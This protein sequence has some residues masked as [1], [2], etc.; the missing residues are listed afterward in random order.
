VNKDYQ[1][2]ASGAAIVPELVM[3]DVVT[4]AEAAREG[5]L[6]LAVSRVMGQVMSSRAANARSTRQRDDVPGSGDPRVRRQPA[7]VEWPGRTS[8]PPLSAHRTHATTGRPRAEQ[9]SLVM[10]GAAADIVER[11]CDP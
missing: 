7:A 5:L 9:A 11:A 6:A 4:L 2:P 10:N 1:K 8:A 3:P